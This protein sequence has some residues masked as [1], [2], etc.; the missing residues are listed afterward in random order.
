MDDEIPAGLR[1][2]FPC[3]SPGDQQ[4]ARERLVLKRLTCPL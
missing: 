1:S 4:R 2:L 3:E